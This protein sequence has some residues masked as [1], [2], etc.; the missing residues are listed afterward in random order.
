MAP[1]NISSTSGAVQEWEGG[2]MDPSSSVKVTCISKQYFMLGQLDGGLLA[3]DHNSKQEGELSSS[4]DSHRSFAPW[5][6]SSIWPSAWRLA[7]DVSSAR[8]LNLVAIDMKLVAVNWKLQIQSFVMGT[9]ALA[10]NNINHLIWGNHFLVTLFS[11]PFVCHQWGSLSDMGMP[12]TREKGSHL[13]PRTTKLTKLRD[14]HDSAT[15]PTADQI[16]D[17]LLHKKG[18]AVW[19]PPGNARN[20][21]VTPHLGVAQVH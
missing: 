20:V 15:A 17:S 16:S 4:S 5:V 18:A 11:T 3:G 7:P 9:K 2:G 19:I 10:R 6:G 8:S 21:T 1:C 14:G 12:P 13:P